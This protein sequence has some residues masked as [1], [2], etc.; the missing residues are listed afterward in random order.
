M[1]EK[2]TTGML[3]NDDKTYTFPPLLS[4]TFEGMNLGA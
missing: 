1:E 4:L 3:L 2:G